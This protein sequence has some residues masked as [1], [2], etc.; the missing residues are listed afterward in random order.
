M[1]GF[2]KGSEVPCESPS[3]RGGI[4]PYSKKEKAGDAQEENKFNT[5]VKEIEEEEPDQTDPMQETMTSDF[6]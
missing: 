1:T 3:A 6:Y 5:T 4:K 2:N